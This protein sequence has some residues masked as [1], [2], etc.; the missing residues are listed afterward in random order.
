V[1]EL[2]TSTENRVHDPI[3]GYK[4]APE[5]LAIVKGDTHIV[6][7][8]VDRGVAKDGSRGSECRERGGHI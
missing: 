4:H 5:K 2:D 7:R 8:H 3:K 1:V 6:G